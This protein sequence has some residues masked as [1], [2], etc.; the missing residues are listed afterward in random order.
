[1][2]CVHIGK[3]SFSTQHLSCTKNDLRSSR[4][5]IAQ[6]LATV[7]TKP[8][9]KGH[10]VFWDICWHTGPTPCSAPPLLL[11]TVHTD[12]RASG[13]DRR[14]GSPPKQGSHTKTCMFEGVSRTPPYQLH[15]Q[16]KTHLHH[17]TPS[18][19]VEHCCVRSIMPPVYY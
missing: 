2:F 13:S 1:M 4:G 7:S 18:C 9:W 6:F 12:V 16:E 14:V 5:C 8:L 15:E 3:F 11:Q 19:M 10:K 17:C